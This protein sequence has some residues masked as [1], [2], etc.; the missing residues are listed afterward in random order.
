MYARSLLI[1]L[2]GLVLSSTQVRAQPANGAS[3]VET[4]SDSLAP[5][6]ALLRSAILP[7][8]GQFYNGKPYKA[9]FFAGFCGLTNNPVQK[10]QFC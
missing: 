10:R 4:R 1:A 7:G 6:A 8:W 3:S 9:L 2:L 5:R